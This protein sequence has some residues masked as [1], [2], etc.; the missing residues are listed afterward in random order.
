MGID[1]KSAAEVPQRFGN[2]STV[3]QQLFSTT[4]SLASG[5]GTEAAP[6]SD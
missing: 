6:F 5:L 4:R 3:D 2:S 1:A